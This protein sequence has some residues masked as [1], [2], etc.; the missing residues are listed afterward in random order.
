[1][2]GTLLLC[3]AYLIIRAGFTKADNLGNAPRHIQMAPQILKW[4]AAFAPAV[5]LACSIYFGYV[6][7]LQVAII[8]DT[9]P[10]SVIGALLP[11][12]DLLFYGFLVCLAALIGIALLFLRRSGSQGSEARG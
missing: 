3:T 12:L 8:G 10:G 4:I 11:V 7:G 5:A 2:L 9:K 6:V 1:L